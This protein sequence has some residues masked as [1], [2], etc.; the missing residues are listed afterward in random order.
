MDDELPAKRA[1]GV[2]SGDLDMD[3]V[4]CVVCL[5]NVTFHFV[6]CCGTPL[7]HSCLGHICT[8]Q[9]A[10]CPGCNTR[11]RGGLNKRYL[12]KAQTKDDTPSQQRLY[13]LFTPVLK[14]EGWLNCMHCNMLFP[15]KSAVRKH[16]SFKCRQ[17][18][19]CNLCNTVVGR[20][21]S[22][23]N[24][25]YLTCK[26]LPCPNSHAGCKHVGPHTCTVTYKDIVTALRQGKT[27]KLQEIQWQTR[28]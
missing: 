17:V 2:T 11:M 7:C 28:E 13:R 20:T 26:A 12:E 25:H 21:S 9:G 4:R 3:I 6:P 22:E 10:P 27:Q 1:K 14:K 16:L 18:V 15:D 19:V 23:K 8:T 24:K 5:S